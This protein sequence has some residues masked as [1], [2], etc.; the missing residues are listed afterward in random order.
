[1]K[2]QIIT[3]DFGKHNEN[4]N[5]AIDRMD[6]AGYYRD[7]STII[8]VP[9][10]GSIPTKAV[11]SWWNMFHPPNQK[12]I[13]MFAVGMEVG[14]AY[15]QTIQAILDHPDLSQYK[16]ILTIEHDNIVPAD[17]HPK[18]VEQMEEHPEFDAI[19]AIYF[20]KGEGGV[21]QIWGDPKDPI[22]NFRPMLPVAGQLVECCG[23]GMGATLFKTS[24]FKDEKMRKPWFKTTAD[25]TN[26]CFTQDLYFW[27]D[28]RKNGHRCAIDC[29]ILVGHYDLEGKFGQPD[30]TW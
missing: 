9:A 13:K 30:M 16:Y 27:M 7:L 2:A 26:G 4:L 12:T 10:L 17:L 1:M 29:S 3:P 23:T 8:I 6:K 22:I 19:G 14:E 20:T 25:T 11:A 18:L 5:A 21:P 24:M 28:A 15:S